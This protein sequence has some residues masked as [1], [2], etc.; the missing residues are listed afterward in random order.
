MFNLFVRNSRLLLLLATAITLGACKKEIET[1]VVQQDKVY[2]WTEVKQLTGIQKIIVGMSS[3]AHSLYMQEAGSFGTLFPRPDYT[4]IRYYYSSTAPNAPPPLPFDISVKLPLSPNVYARKL[5][6]GDSVLIVYP[7][8]SPLTFALGGQS[9]IHLRRLDPHAVQYIDN[10]NY[11]FFP[12]GAINSN[13]Q[14]L[15]GYSADNNAQDPAI[16][17]V[18]SKIT[19][20]GI[21]SG[22]AAVIE[23]ATA[24]SR[25]LRIPLTSQSDGCLK[26]V[27]AV[28]DY[29]IADCSQL[30]LFKITQSGSIKQVYGPT[31]LTTLYK[32]Q[33]VIYGIVGDGTS[34]LT[35]RDNG[36][37]WQKSTGV[38]NYF[39]IC[40]FYPVGDSLVAISHHIANNS[41]FSVRWQGTT[42]RLRQLKN[43]GLGQADFSDLAQLGDTVYLATTNGL[44]KRP[45]KIFFES[46]P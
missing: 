44:F 33:G 17:F 38:P 12:F 11:D 25:T 31:Y 27:A 1:I 7:P 34:L 23:D 22:N 29:F 6:S 43:D 20:H 13:N 16:R 24:D 40:T 45:L 4:G 37:T 41:L 5:F 36:E 26:S 10:K 39:Q 46:K 3:D 21:G 9:Q 8:S 42:Y 19:L 14:L 18:L 30:G 2:S 28:D 15:F 35:S 32:W